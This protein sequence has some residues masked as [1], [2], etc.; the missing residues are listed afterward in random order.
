MGRLICISNRIP[1]GANPSGGLVVALGDVLE[2]TGG[3]W[4]GTSGEIADTPA[5]E[6]REIEGGPFRRYCFDLTQE[7]Q[8]N[9]YAGYSNSVLWP[10]FHGRAD[11]MDIHQ[12]YLGVYKQVNRRIAKLVAPF[13]KPDDRIWVQDYHLLPLAYELRLMGVTNPIGFFLH[14]PFPGPTAM[15]ALPNGR[16]VCQWIANYDLVGLQAERD[17]RACLHS[18]I[19][20]A[21]A[22]N[23]GAGYVHL[24]PRQCRIAAFPISIDAREFQE[25]AEAE[26]DKL[27]AG[28]VKDHRRLMIGVDRLDYSKGVPH[29]FRAFGEFLERHED[30]HRYVSLLQI[31]PPTREGVQAYDDIREETEHLSGRINGQFA[32]IQWVPIRF[33]NRAV[34]REVLAGLYRASHVALVTPLMDGMNLVAKEFIAAQNPD[35]PGVLMLSQF[36]GAAEQMD[37]ALMVNP[38]DP[39]QVA[40]SML[41]ALMMSRGER[42]E[43]YRSLMTG[44]TTYDVHWW[45]KS[46]LDALG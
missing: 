17:V 33:I 30:W 39:E 9:Y 37:A 41:T 19:E 27:P 29:R 5:A 28:I 43:R 35:D 18:M 7:E 11:L 1:T 23:L 20:I 24:S 32:D 14:T 46:F 3:I 8:D 13:L 45:S 40:T 22:S 6:L 12:E 25:L 21:D 36:A 15:Q 42:R 34:P 44:L 16:E 31:S 4:I 38:H 10:L 26:F 2:E